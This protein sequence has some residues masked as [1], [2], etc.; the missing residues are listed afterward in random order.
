MKRAG[1]ALLLALLGSTARAR[2]DVT[3]E[4]RVDVRPARE[5][6][7][8][9]T[10][11]K[12]EP[13]DVKVLEDI[14]A[15]ELSIRDS[16]REKVVFERDLKAAFDR[17][18][19]VAVFDFRSVREQADRWTALVAILE[20]RSAELSRMA[21]SQASALLP[22]DRP[23]SAKLVVA[24][25][26]GLAGLGDH[27][28]ARNPE[29]GEIVVVDLARAVADSEGEP[30][31]A[32]FARM[33]RLIAA[34]AFR[35]AWAIY[36]AES[37]SW[38]P[39]SVAPPAFETFERIVAETGPAA[40]FSVDE[41]F[42]PLSTWLKELQKKSFNELERAAERL[43]DADKDLDGRVE[44]LTEMKR[45]DFARRVAAPAGMFM[46]DG[47]RQVAG[48]DGLKAA[49]AGGPRAFFQAYDRASQKNKDLTPLSKLLRERLFAGKA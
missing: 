1:A 39:T 24:F 6:L 13:S 35:Q 19:Y 41:A 21:G 44:A 36:R 29:G 15:I 42:F 23:V 20:A 3:L 22:T 5:I 7:G 49:M 32:R 48:V 4:I 17:E 2:A 27:I 26:F 40:L 31:E 11:P 43:A 8:T 37:P 28:V 38:K 30:P 12:W 47:I 46:A 14:P 10:R 16:G 45:P 9:L 25:S 33:A 34:E 18:S